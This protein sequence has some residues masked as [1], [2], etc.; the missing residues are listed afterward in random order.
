[1]TK[2]ARA[3]RIRVCGCGH[4]EGL[5]L[6]NTKDPTKR[7]QC[8]RCGEQCKHFKVKWGGRG[9]RTKTFVSPVL[10][11]APPLDEVRHPGLM[12]AFGKLEANVLRSLG[13][14]RVAL[15]N[16]P[17]HVTRITGLRQHSVIGVDPMLRDVSSPRPRPSRPVTHHGQAALDARDPLPKGERRVLTAIAQHP[18]GVDRDQV[19]AL[20]GYKRS[21][22]DAYVKRLSDKGLL[23][24]DAD[25]IFA[26]AD[27]I[28]ALGTDY[29]PLPAGDALCK[30]W[31]EKLPGG[32]SLVLQCL[33]RSYPHYVS[34]DSVTTSTGYKRS[35]RDAYISRLEKRKLVDTNSSGV[36]MSP[37]L[38][39]S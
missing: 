22:R 23:D 7:G 32:E 17:A 12:E 27:G 33:A 35:T 37:T 16:Q 6:V 13:E 14:F 4:E 5:H 21:T 28:A 19:T 24:E 34:R 3:P 15:G 26:N 38:S 39:G 20:T 30:Y 29:R 9:P 31:I 25:R 2:T 11:G 8:T 36:R 1:M 10:D 18:H